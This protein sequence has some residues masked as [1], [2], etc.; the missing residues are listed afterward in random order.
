[1]KGCKLFD[2]ANGNVGVHGAIISSGVCTDRQQE[3]SRSVCAV[4]DG[5]NPGPGT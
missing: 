2:D 3:R 4:C 5:V 1:M